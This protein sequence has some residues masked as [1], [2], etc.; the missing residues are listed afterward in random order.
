MSF[1]Y[2]KPTERLSTIYTPIPTAKWIYKLVKHVKPKWILDPC[3]GSG[4]FIAPWFG[5]VETVGVDVDPQPI[6]NTLLPKDFHFIMKAFENCKREQFPHD[7]PLVLCNP[8]FNGHWQRKHY[9]DVFLMKIL[10]L[11]GPAVPIV[12]CCPMGFRL[13]QRKE[14]SRVSQYRINLPE[15]KSIISCPIDLYPETQFHTEILLFNIKRVKPHYW[16]P[17]EA[18]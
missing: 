1:A 4:N 8:P 10:E 12:F 2:T 16:L 9:P 5:R 3:V 14:S 15:I 11:F 18:M 7:L 13:N 17:L 6:E